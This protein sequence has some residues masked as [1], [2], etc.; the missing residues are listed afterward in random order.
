[1]FPLEGRRLDAAMSYFDTAEV[2]SRY[3]VMPLAEMTRRR[4]LTE[5]MRLYAEHAQALARR[6]AL[7]SL[8]RASLPGSRVDLVIAVSCTGIMMPSL[9][10]HL[11]RPLA[12][13]P[14]VR[15]LPITELGCVG[16]AA[17][18]SRAHDYLVGHPDGVVL[19]VAVELPS[20]NFQPLDV[21]PDNLI[22]S[23]LFGDG[24]VAVVMTG[25]RLGAPRSPPGGGGGGGGE[26]DGGRVAPV[27]VLGTHCH[28]VPDSTHVLGFD[29]RDDGFH[30]VLSREIPGLLRGAAVDLFR[31]LAAQG[32]ATPR[33]IRAF[34]L[35]PGGKRILAAVQEAL[36]LEPVDTQ[37]SWDVLREFG[38]Q[39]SAS[40]L[41]VLERW[42]TQRPQPA[43]TLGAMAA[44]GPGLTAESVLLQWM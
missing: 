44:F 13:R 8:A 22:S 36:G 32:E 33:D 9:D 37:P 43:G 23:A 12:L 15:R 40:V 16:G 26:R 25:D 5:T 38:N 11:I 2:D 34:V 29:L 28:T 35:H 20:L 6:V 24:A 41:F 21:S 19:V 14:D 4:T 1:M 31:R 30:T 10:A 7:D 42:M 3:S 17:A 39:S 18:V 27:R